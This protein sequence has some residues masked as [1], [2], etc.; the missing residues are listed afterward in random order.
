MRG[1]KDHK[2]LKFNSTSLSPVCPE[3]HIEKANCIK[4]VQFP[5]I[6]SDCSSSLLTSTV[7]L[8]QALPFCLFVCFY[9]WFDG[10]RHRSHA[11]RPA[12]DPP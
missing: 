10:T 2:S 6:I 11:V 5:A 9:F 7:T 1:H 4:S 12:A 8:E 3:S